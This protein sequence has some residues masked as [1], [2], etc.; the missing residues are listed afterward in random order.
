MA[1]SA[2]A[3]IASA[4]AVAAEIVTVSTLATMAT[5]VSVVGAVT[6]NKTLMKLGAGMGIASLGS[7]LLSTATDGAASAAGAA[8]D[9]SAAETARLAA[10]EQAASA[11]GDAAT[12]TT[13]AVADTSTGIAQHSLDTMS[14]DPAAAEAAAPIGDGGGSIVSQARSTVAPSAADVASTSSAIEPASSTLGAS[15]PTS[16]AEAGVVGPTGPADVGAPS[17]PA[18]SIRTPGDFARYDRANLPVGGAQIQDSNSFFG[19]AFDWMEKNKTLTAGAM[20]LAGGAL[21]GLGDAQQADR[22]YDLKQR[23]FANASAQP[24]VNFTVNPNANVYQS[25]PQQYAGIVA[26]AR[27]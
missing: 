9:Q 22:L 14:L 11:A 23:E 1:I 20:N 16:P 5:V 12:A 15:A 24:T 8:V 26:R 6:G 17:S 18:D 27:G 25:K 21:K 2:V 10:G 19:K 3:A 4:G 7:S 13:G